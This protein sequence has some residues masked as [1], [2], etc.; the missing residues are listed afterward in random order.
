MN[1]TDLI[2]NSLCYNSESRQKAKYKNREINTS[3]QIVSD[4]SIFVFM[5][6]IKREF[7]EEVSFHFTS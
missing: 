1:K 4:E 7:M 5:E 3:T 2:L 6:Q